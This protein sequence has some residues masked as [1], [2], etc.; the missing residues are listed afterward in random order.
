MPMTGLEEMKAAIE[1]ES[2]VERAEIDRRHVI[3]ILRGFLVIIPM[4]CLL[5][6]I[7]KIHGVWW[8]FPATE[9]LVAVIGNRPDVFGKRP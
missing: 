8:A 4:A 1:E 9:L 6:W 3:S 2:R 5:S 7:G